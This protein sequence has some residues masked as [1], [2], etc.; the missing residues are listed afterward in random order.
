MDT[1][2]NATNLREAYNKVSVVGILSE[3]DIKEEIIEGAK[4]LT[5]S[6]T[7]KTSELNFVRFNI[8]VAEKKKDGSANQIYSSML[9]V[10]NEYKSIADVG[11][12]EADKVIVNAKQGINI[13]RSSKTGKSIVGFKSNF[14]NR[15]KNEEEFTPKAEFEIEVYIKNISYEMSNGEQTGRVLVYGLVPTYGGGIEDITLVADEEIG[16]AIMNT[17][18]AGQTVEFFGDIVNNRIETSVEISMAIGK[19]RFEKTVTY[20][21]DMLIT[22]ASVAYEEGISA[23]PPYDK[24]AID[25]ALQERETKIANE[26]A[27]NNKQNDSRPSGAAKGRSM[28]W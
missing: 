7:I 28:N 23:V 20:K 15:V 2:N 6:L 16:E 27:Q 13:Y 19:P 8:R 12:A 22:G 3:K 14:F 10:K 21:N 4:Y 25:K 1:I 11:E 18:Q 26:Q 24:A 9:T 5:G 17:Y